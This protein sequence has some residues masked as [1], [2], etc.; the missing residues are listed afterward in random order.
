MLRLAGRLRR[1]ATHCGCRTS[2]AMDVHGPPTRLS[3]TSAGLSTSM[4]RGSGSRRQSSSRST[5]ATFED[6]DGEDEED[7]A[8][9]IGVPQ[10]EDAPFTQPSQQA[11]RRQ[12]RPCDPYT[13]G[14][15]ALG[16]GKGKTRRQ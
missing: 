2:V 4:Q 6:S 8:E 1:A 11:P 12:C 5:G 13:P 9:E 3:D 14:T 16:K 15:D 7:R 10:L